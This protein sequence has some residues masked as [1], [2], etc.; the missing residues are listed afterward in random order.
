MIQIQNAVSE[1]TLVPAQS[2]WQ[3]VEAVL[4]RHYYKP[5]LQ[6][7]RALYAAR[8]GSPLLTPRGCTRGRCRISSSSWKRRSSEALRAPDPE[9]GATQNGSRSRG[10]VVALQR[11]GKRLDGRCLYRYRLGPGITPGV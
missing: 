7:A 6:A 5:D 1:E 9:S 4:Q 10:G 8:E 2:A 11:F 3:Q